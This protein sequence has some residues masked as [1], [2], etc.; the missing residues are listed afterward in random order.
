MQ[1]TGIPVLHPRDHDPA[2]VGCKD[3]L[4]RVEI[5]PVIHALI[6]LRHK[7]S[8]LTVVLPDQAE[9]PVAIVIF[10]SVRQHVHRARQD[11]LFAVQFKEIRTLPHSPDPVSVDRELFLKFPVVRIPSREQQYLSAL[12]FFVD[13]RGSQKAVRIF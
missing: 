1:I 7:S 3:C 8:C 13:H 6:C 10:Q 9:S 5:N 2:A 12:L 4:F 11:H